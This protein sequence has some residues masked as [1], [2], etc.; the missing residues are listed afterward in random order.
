[1]GSSE[2]EYAAMGKSFGDR[3]RRC[4]EQMRLLKRL[5]CE[6]TLDFDDGSERIVGAGINPLPVQRP[7]P[8]WIGA[9]A[10]PVA[11]VIRRIGALADGWFVLASPAEF[12]DISARIGDAAVAAGRNPGD[13]GTEAGVAVVGPREAEWRERVSGWRE[14]GL[15]YLCL[16][17]LGGELSVSEHLKKLEEVSKQIP[18]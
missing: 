6:E 11:T 15:S 3:G 8:M 5:W 1:I 13:I 18:N 7:I 9:K 14:I 10:N 16:R 17:T 4:D 12:T 2:E